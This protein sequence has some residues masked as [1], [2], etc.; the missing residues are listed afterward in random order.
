MR[1]A[2]LRSPTGAPHARVVV[3]VGAAGGVGATTLGALLAAGRVRAGGPVSLVDLHPGRGGVEVLLGVEEAPGA[4]WADLAGVRGALAP[5]DLDGVLPVW[6]GVGVLGHDR[7]PGG[8][9]P[10]V[11]ASAVAALASTGTVLVDLPARSVLADVG[12]GVATALLAAG[13][14]CVLLT[15]QDVTGLAAAIGVREALDAHPV[16]L[17]LRARPGARVAP[18]EAAHLLDLPLAGVLPTARGVAGAVDRGLGPVVGARSRLAR[19]VARVWQG[20]AG[21]GG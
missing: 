11:V 9:A 21:D 10:E 2:H 15:G 4:R 5:A 1:R 8:P 17:V 13:A 20:V 18:L 12:G 3:V 6:R 19:A 14:G 7:R 16:H